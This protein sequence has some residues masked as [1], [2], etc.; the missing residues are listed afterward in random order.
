MGFRQDWA[1]FFHCSMERP[2]SA[3]IIGVHHCLA[4][5]HPWDISFI[6]P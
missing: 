4:T 6:L 3:W 2:I 5:T 1:C